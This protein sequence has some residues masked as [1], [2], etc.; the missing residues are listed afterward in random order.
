MVHQEHRH[1]RSTQAYRQ[2]KRTASKAV[3]EEFDKTN[4]ELSTVTDIITP[5]F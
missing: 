4:L 1:H 2:T 5:M 3:Q